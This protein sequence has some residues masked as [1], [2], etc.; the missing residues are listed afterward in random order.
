MTEP[1]PPNLVPL[2]EAPF[3]LQFGPPLEPEI[4]GEP[5]LHSVLSAFA[6]G[7][8]YVSRVGRG[9]FIQCRAADGSF[10][11]QFVIDDRRYLGDDA[12]L[13]SCEL[14][15]RGGIVTPERT[16]RAV[17][18]AIKAAVTAEMFEISARRDEL[19]TPILVPVSAWRVS[20]I[21]NWHL[22][23]AKLSTGAEL[24]DVKVGHPGTGHISERRDSEPA[25]KGTGGPRLK[26]DWE[27]AYIEMARIA[28]LDE[29]PPRSCAEMQERLREW[30]MQ[31]RRDHDH[32]ADS[33]LR[34]KVKL[35]WTRMGYE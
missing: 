14:A 25:K 4:D 17:E 18:T 2:N 31:Q 32:P 16:C 26:Y 24:F 29:N 3:K 5:E 19:G 11:A 28:F 6:S 35:F 1:N 13:S 27:G 7:S 15:A 12:K 33:L 21:T 9:F 30:F 10:G 34:D 23:R 8:I 20:R 22:N